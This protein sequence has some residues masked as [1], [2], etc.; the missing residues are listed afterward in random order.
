MDDLTFTRKAR[1]LAKEL[2]K[3]AKENEPQIT[4]D[5][6]TIAKE[7]AAEMVG[8]ENKFKAEMSLVRKI[9]DTAKASS[10]EL[11][12]AADRIN[13]A[14]RYSFIFPTEHYTEGLS[15]TIGHLRKA[16]Y[17]IPEDKIWNAWRFIG[18]KQDR[19]YRGINITLISSQ[20]Q[21]FEL[22]FHT[23]ASFDLK[24]ETHDLYKEARL[25][26]TLPERRRE[27]KEFVLKKA[28]SV[29]IPKGAKQWN[30]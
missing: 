3:Q 5:L 28:E 7:I 13:D 23:E 14:L 8:L 11:W 15:Q 2:L 25:M 24:T 12:Q 19:G 17:Q 21:R 30:M 6:Q 27:I 29:E 22:Q 16:D 20:K 1:R 9:S 10:Q 26:G 18:S 4:I